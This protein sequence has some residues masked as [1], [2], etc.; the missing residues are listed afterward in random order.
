MALDGCLEC[1]DGERAGGDPAG[2][3]RDEEDDGGAGRGGARAGRRF[4]RSAWRFRARRIEPFTERELWERE[5]LIFLRERE[6]LREASVVSTEMSGGAAV[7]SV[8][9][10]LPEFDASENTLWR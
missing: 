5:R 7:R 10:L 9:E 4:I 8:R 2:G 1:R 3:G 6:L